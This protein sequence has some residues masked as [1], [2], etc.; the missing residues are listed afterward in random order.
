[1]SHGSGNGAWL[2]IKIAGTIVCSLL[3]IIALVAFINGRLTWWGR[4]P[5]INDPTPLLE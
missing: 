3:C 2:G 4:Y 5:N 1:M